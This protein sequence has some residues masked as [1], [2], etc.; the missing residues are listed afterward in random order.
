MNSCRCGACAVSGASKRGSDTTERDAVC[1]RSQNLANTLACNVCMVQRHLGAEDVQRK[2]AEHISVKEEHVERR[3]TVARAAEMRM[4]VRHE[5]EL[6]KRQSSVR[7]GKIQTENAVRE[8]KQQIEEREQSVRDAR[9]VLHWKDYRSSIIKPDPELRRRKREATLLSEWRAAVQEERERVHD[10]RTS[11][12]EVR[13]NNMP[14][15]SIIKSKD[16]IA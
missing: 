7:E 11:R 13:E 14:R 3:K 12:L 4:H 1:G 8:T 9:P 5:K 16:V 2:R 15:H 6:S 10:L